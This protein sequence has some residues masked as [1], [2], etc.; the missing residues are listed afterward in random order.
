[1]LEI[2][3]LSL[4]Y[5]KA[6]KALFSDVNIKLRAGELLILKGVNGSGKTS[7]LNSIAG[8]IPEHIHGELAG[9]IALNGLELR[10]YPLRERYRY[11]AYQMSDPDAQIFFPDSEK[12][13]SFALE[14]MGIKPLEIRQRIDVAAD[15]FHLKHIYA[16]DPST[17]S[18]GQKKRLLFAVC[19][20]LDT[21]LILLDEPTVSLSEGGKEL[22]K[23]W[24]KS[25]LHQGKIIIAANHDSA[26]DDF[27][28]QVIT[29]GSLN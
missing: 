2:K 17:L 16:Q 3:R 18:Q 24:L 6:A 22:L 26:C 1:M 29:L 23:E 7:L 10:S 9:S 12:E 8:V 27:C 28:T 21:Q 19:A 4:L 14:N 13:L 25:L 11:L 15:R 5:P 20:A